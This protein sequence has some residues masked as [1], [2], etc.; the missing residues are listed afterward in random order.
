MIEALEYLN[1]SD[2]KDKMLPYEPYPALTPRP[3]QKQTTKVHEKHMLV[4][5]RVSGCSK[6]DQNGKPLDYLVDKE[7]GHTTGNAQ[8]MSNTSGEAEAGMALL[9]ELAYEDK[10][11][12]A[13]FIKAVQEGNLA[14]L[15]EF[16]AFFKSKGFN[17]EHFPV[18]P[19]IIIA[20]VGSPKAV[21]HVQ[22]WSSNTF[23][24]NDQL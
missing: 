21:E 15:Q 11:G 12:S 3:Y 18:N 20:V 6:E 1:L 24:W 9:P 10:E 17:F 22:S 4:G 13:K 7:I 19:L 14:V 23:N 2:L 5:I 16:E 8:S